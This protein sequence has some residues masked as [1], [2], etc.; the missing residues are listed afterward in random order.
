MEPIDERI[1]AAQLMALR[2]ERGAPQ[3]IAK[4]LGVAAMPPH[5]GR[6]TEKEI[7]EFVETGDAT[8]AAQLIHGAA[9]RRTRAGDSAA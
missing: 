2:R 9:V 8:L 4:L 5:L 7:A 6:R 3:A 1:T